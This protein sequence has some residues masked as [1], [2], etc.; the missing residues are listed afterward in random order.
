MA[1]ADGRIVL[2]RSHTLDP[3]DPEDQYVLT[4]R[5]DQVEGRVIKLHG[6]GVAAG[7]GDRGCG[8]GRGQAGRGE[9]AGEAGYQP[10]LAV[11][12]GAILSTD[13]EGG[14]F[15]AEF[16]ALLQAVLDAQAADGATSLV[17][18]PM[19]DALIA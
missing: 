2:S 12:H 10:L 5:Q 16:G 13:A 17:T 14:A 9:A 8:A 11:A 18:P 6:L 3:R 1:D 4:A 7:A 15:A 19:Q